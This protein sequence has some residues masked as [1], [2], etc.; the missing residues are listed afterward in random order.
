MPAAALPCNQC[1]PLLVVQHDVGQPDVLGR[2]IQ[3]GDAA[4]LLRIPLELVILPL[5][6][7]NRAAPK[8]VL[9]LLLLLRRCD[10][11]VFSFRFII[12]FR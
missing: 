4:V 6:E 1:Q 12:R 8:R 5:L 9:L 2:H 10:D 3:L 11:T 7:A